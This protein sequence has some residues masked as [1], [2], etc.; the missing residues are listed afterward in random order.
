LGLIQI[1]FVNP[2]LA[3]EIAFAA[4]ILLASIAILAVAGGENR[5]V[6]RFAYFAFACE[7]IYVVGETLGSLLGSSGFLF[8]GG[9]VLAIIAFAVMKLEKR[10]KAGEGRS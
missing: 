8:L 6:R 2:G 5:L 10:F 1:D 9:L 7:T 4:L 3:A